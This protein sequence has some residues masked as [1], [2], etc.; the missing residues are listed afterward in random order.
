LE[1]IYELTKNSNKELV[2]SYEKRI[3]YSQNKEANLS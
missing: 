2:I 1:L 3:F